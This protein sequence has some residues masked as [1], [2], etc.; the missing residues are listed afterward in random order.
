M[1]HTSAD[2]DAT[3]IRKI[4]ERGLPPGITLNPNQICNL[5]K[6]IELYI[7]TTDGVK[8]IRELHAKIHDHDE[9]IWG[10]VQLFTNLRS[11]ACNLASELCD[12]LQG[13]SSRD[14]TFLLEEYLAMLHEKD[15]DF[16]YQMFKTSEGRFKG[17]AW[18]TKAMRSNTHRFGHTVS[19]DA[20]KRELNSLCWP[21]VAVTSLNDVNKVCILVEGV[22][23][24][25]SEESYKFLIDCLMKMGNRVPSKYYC[26]IADGFFSKSMI[27]RLG[28]TNSEFITD[29]WHFREAAKKRF[30]ITYEKVRNCSCIIVRTNV[31]DYLSPS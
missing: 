8:D 22:L 5:R 23:V 15:A 29:R 28:F 21:Y 25:E 19:I 11:E 31:V 12:Q 17:A 24:D 9:D 10:S 27:K 7:P 20:L 4:A 30:G 26:V 1:L 13:S 16:T 2:I 6:R 14:H 18:M 3:T